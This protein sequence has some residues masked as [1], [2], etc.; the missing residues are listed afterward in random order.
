MTKIKP[1]P[2][3]KSLEA[4]FRYSPFTGE[5]KNWE[6]GHIANR[7][8][9]KGKYIQVEFKNQT[10]Q[11]HR[12]CFY[13]GTK[14]DPKEWQID[15]R[16]QVTTNNKLENL[17]LRDNGGQQ[18][19]TKIRS[20]CKSGYRGVFFDEKSGKWRAYIADPQKKGRKIF[21]YYGDSKEKAIE[22]RLIAEKK[23]YPGFYSVNAAK[24]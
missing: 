3:L 10:W 13:L 7:L 8:D 11:A 17:R 14:K 16:D 22:A 15:H 2:P 19:N 24:A 1:L 9:S 20:N 18:H 21:L 23:Y 6:T 4:H 12:I 5:L